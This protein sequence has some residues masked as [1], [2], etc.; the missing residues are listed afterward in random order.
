MNILFLIGNGFDLNVGLNTRFKDALES[1]LKEKTI[2]SEVEKSKGTSKN[3][4][5]FFL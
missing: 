2:C 5:Y 3:S 4:I 1:Y